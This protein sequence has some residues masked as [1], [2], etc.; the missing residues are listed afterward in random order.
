MRLQLAVTFE[1]GA[2]HARNQ[3]PCFAG[4][5]TGLDRDTAARIAGNGVK[6]LGGNR[7]AVV[8]VAWR[9]GIQIPKNRSQSPRGRK[10]SFPFKQGPR[11]RLRRAAGAAAPSG[12][13]KLH[14]LSE[15]GGNI[16]TRSPSGTARAP[17]NIRRPCP[18]PVQAAARRLKCAIRQ[19]ICCRSVHRAN[20]RCRAG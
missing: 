17:S 9:H 16:L 11:N 15:R 3:H 5:G 2:Q 20:A 13:R 8:F 12:G 18:R 7:L 1:Q 6:N 14:A 19:A 10:N 4:A